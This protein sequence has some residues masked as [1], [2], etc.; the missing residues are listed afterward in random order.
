MVKSPPLTTHSTECANHLWMFLLLLPHWRWGC[1]RALLSSSYFSS[2]CFFFILILRKAIGL[3]RPE[4]EGLCLTT[5]Q[6][7]QRQWQHK[8]SL[9]LGH[10]V[11]M[12]GDW[13][14][15]PRPRVPSAKSVPSPLLLTPCSSDKTV[16]CH[17]LYGPLNFSSN[18]FL[19]LMIAHLLWATGM[20]CL[21]LKCHSFGEKWILVKL[22]QNSGSQPLNHFGSVFYP[23]G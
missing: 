6:V 7:Q 4:P 21:I 11:W 16:N 5:D 19:N 14:Q 18:S 8:V 22:L 23:K 12:W 17:F 15:E 13:E 10:A 1:W 20:F 2:L 3:P 9:W